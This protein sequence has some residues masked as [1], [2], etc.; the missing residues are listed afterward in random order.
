[1]QQFFSG[2][3]APKLIVFAVGDVQF[4]VVK[5]AG[6]NIFCAQCGIKDFILAQRLQ[7]NFGL[8]PGFGL[9]L[10][11]EQGAFG[12]HLLQHNAC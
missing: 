5:E 1:M 11:R 6:Q 10:G 7:E 8:V 9:F 2:A 12:G 4:I 3:A